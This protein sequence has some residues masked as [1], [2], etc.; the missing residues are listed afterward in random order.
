MDK[1]QH[2]AS[3]PGLGYRLLRTAS[4]QYGVT[5]AQL[6]PSQQQQAERIAAKELAL[7]HLV[8]A[9]REAREV[10]V[11]VS[12]VKNALRQIRD[13]YESD[14]VFD[15]VLAANHLTTQDLES[16][17][18]RELRVDAVLTYVSSKVAEVDDTEV[19]LFYYMHRERF[20]QPETRTARHILITINPE[21]P[22]NTR[23]AAQE[24]LATIARRV[25]KNPGR[26]EEQAMQ[27]SECPTS[28]HGGLLGQV[29]PGTLYPELEKVLFALQAGEVSDI[30]E[31][32][33]GLHILRCEAIA[34][35]HLAP[36]P[37]VRAKL[38]ESLTERQRNLYQRRWLKSLATA[39]PNADPVG[40][41]ES[42]Q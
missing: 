34:P 40:I 16:A 26:F 18:A 38:R 42:T 12:E 9:S 35:E 30:V 15:E 39:N 2:S 28:L 41:K 20:T 32:P 29:K 33:V 10:V 27:H 1:S 11:P 14:D 8:L 24:R 25:A 31:S 22:E 3:E 17:L 23:E 21:Y 36:F 13:R 37:E 6:D 7:E 5:P 19:R 4:D